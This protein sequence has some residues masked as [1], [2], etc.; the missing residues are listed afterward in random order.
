MDISAG[1]GPGM[2]HKPSNAVILHG[3]HAR[4]AWGGCAARATIS[5]VGKNK[6]RSATDLGKRRDDSGRPASHQ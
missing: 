5:L 2:Q 1:T 3:L 6:N 4:A